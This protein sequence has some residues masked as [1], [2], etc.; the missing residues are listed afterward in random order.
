MGITSF[1][2]VGEHA[3]CINALLLVLC[4]EAN[5]DGKSVEASVPRKAVS[6]CV[7]PPQWC[8]PRSWFP[9]GW[10]IGF[11]VLS[12]FAFFVFAGGIPEVEVNV[13]FFSS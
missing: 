2:K 3:G 1:N 13:G 6:G 7:K 5:A 10:P 4:P 9:Q 12:K 11:T 8:P